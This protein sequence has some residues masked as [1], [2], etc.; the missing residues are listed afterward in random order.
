M[1]KRILGSC[2]LCGG[3]VSVP[4]AFLSLV[5]PVPACESCGAVPRDAAPPRLP[6]LPPRVRL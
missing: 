6:M 5:P 1:S 3:T 2:G 4:L